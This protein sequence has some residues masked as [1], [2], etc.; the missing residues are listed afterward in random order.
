MDPYE[1]NEDDSRGSMSNSSSGGEG[2]P[3]PAPRDPAG[4]RNSR[5]SSDLAP[6]ANRAR[7]QGTGSDHLQDFEFV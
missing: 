7:S 4:G 2:D 3:K 5:G 1:D 6:P